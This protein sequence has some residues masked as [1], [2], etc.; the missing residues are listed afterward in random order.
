MVEQIRISPEEVRGYGNVCEEHTLEDFTVNVSSLSKVSETVH[1][2]LTNTYKLLYSVYG[3]MFDFDKGAKQLYLQTNEADTLSLGFDTVNKQLYLVDENDTGF[4]LDFDEDTNELYITDDA[5]PVVHNYSLALDQSSYTTTGSL[6][7]SATLLDDGVPVNG[8]TVSFT[9]GTSTVTATTDSN[10][11]ATATVTFSASGTLTASYSNVSDTATVTVQQGYLF[12]DDATTDNS[13]LYD[14][15]SLTGSSFTYDSTNQAYLLNVTSNNSITSLFIKDFNSVPNNCK[16]TVDLQIPSNTG[17]T[18]VQGGLLV[19]NNNKTNGILCMEEYTS[20]RSKRSLGTTT[21]PTGTHGNKVVSD[22]NF[23][24]TNY[25]GVWL[26][27][28]LT[29]NSGS[30]SAKWY[31]NNQS[32]IVEDTMS[33]TVLADNTNR[34]GILMSYNSNSKLLFKNLKVETLQE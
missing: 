25:R 1:G 10:G 30:V 32:L 23:P 20:S 19:M 28:V 34:V 7:V 26:T 31:D 12:Y 21:A 6:S 24:V 27:L 11:V 13:N 4:S 18:N 2:A 22:Q 5:P 16:V 17:T 9:G 29:V 14:T 15:T 33:A 8:A 3:L